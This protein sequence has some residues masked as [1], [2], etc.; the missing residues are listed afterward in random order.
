MVSIGKFWTSVGMASK[1]ATF[2]W[3][4]ASFNFGY[5][6][7]HVIRCSWRQPV[8]TCTHFLWLWCCHQWSWWSHIQVLHA[9]KHHRQSKWW[10][11]I[12]LLLFQHLK[13]YL[14]DFYISKTVKVRGCSANFD[15]SP[16]WSVRLRFG[17]N[18]CML[19]LNLYR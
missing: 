2:H 17:F 18:G 9:E 19:G 7:L 15:S 1:Q 16:L 3:C 13:I 4:F 8:Q 11:K 14:G 6:N 12:D 10:S 5:I